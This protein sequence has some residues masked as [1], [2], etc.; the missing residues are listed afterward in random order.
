[1]IRLDNV[2]KYFATPSGRK[3]VLKNLDLELPGAVNIGVLGLNGSGKSTLLRLIGGIDFPSEGSIDIQGSISWPMGL[4]DGVQG[5]LTGRQNAQFVCRIY[6]DSNDVIQ[7][8]MHFIK[9]LA[10]LHDYFDMP[11]K[12]YSSGMRSRLKFAVSMAFDFDIYLFDEIGAVG[13]ARFRKKSKAVLKERSG[14][15]NYIMVSHNTNDLVK[16]CD[17]LAILNDGALE[18]FDNIKAGIKHYRQNIIPM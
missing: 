14:R 2:S 12:T 8:K 16:D 17:V 9:D 7:E 18:V 4:A 6:G 13:D 5:S 11:V 10:E 15:A 3:Y 1:M